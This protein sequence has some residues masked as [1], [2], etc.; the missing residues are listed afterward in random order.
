MRLLAGSYDRSR[1]VWTG[2]L[3]EEG[4]PRYRCYHRHEKRAEARQCARDA[5]AALKADPE[6]LP[7][8][9]VVYHESERFMS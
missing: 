7:R 9:W 3:R 8:G 2:L 4:Y 6:R 5:L 1:P